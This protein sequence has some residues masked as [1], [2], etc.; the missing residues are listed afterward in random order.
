MYGAAGVAFAG[1]VGCLAA[2]A[3]YERSLTPGL[4]TDAIKNIPSV[5]GVATSLKWAA[6]PPWAV[7]RPH[8]PQ[9][10]VPAQPL[11]PA[12]YRIPTEQS[13]I[14]ITI[15][16]GMVPNEAALDI[17]IR[18]GVVAS[19][20]L[21]DKV[22][23]HHYDYFK[24]WQMAGSTVQ[25]HTVNHPNLKLLPYDQQKAEIC[26][27]N[28]H[29]HGGTGAN[30]TLFRPPYGFYTEDTR[31]AVAECG[32]KALV[33]WTATVSDGA[34][35]YQGT[36]HLKPGDIVLLHFTP[37]LDTDLNVLFTA[38]DQQGLGIGRLEDWLH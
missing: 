11:A 38:A 27:N 34:L 20:F 32:L 14:F 28:I 25:N 22:A 19:L 23:K 4:G 1:F 10:A 13:V 8:T 36:D 12:V 15:D 6:S 30:P 24:R 17:M 16:D 35:H 3:M 2:M 26:H 7:V 31:R 21:N 5:L 37:K 33:W 29:L 9:T 18:R